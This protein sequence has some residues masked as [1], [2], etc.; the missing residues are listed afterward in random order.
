MPDFLV[1][2]FMVLLLCVSFM[3]LCE[4]FVKGDRD[5]LTISIVCFILFLCGGIWIYNASHQP[6]KI[7]KQIVLPVLTTGNVQYI[8]YEDSYKNLECVNLNEELKSKIPDGSKIRVTF[9]NPYRLGI[10]S[11]DDNI[12]FELI[13]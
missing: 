7:D 1:I 2:I 9:F 3:C 6:K 10:L 11:T 8:V 13:K 5:S 4:G 12:K